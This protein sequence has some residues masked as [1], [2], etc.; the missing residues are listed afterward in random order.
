[1]ADFRN[2]AEALRVWDESLPVREE[3]WE[4]VVDLPTLK[5][6]EDEDGKAMELVHQAF[7]ADT[8]EFNNIEQC[9]LIH[10]DDPFIRRIVRENL[11]ADAKLRQ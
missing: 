4:N 8:K 9:R 1:M 10:P 2:T 5:H 11:R 6:A 7:H 3:N